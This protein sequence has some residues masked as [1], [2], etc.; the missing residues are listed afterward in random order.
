MPVVCVSLEKGPGLHESPRAWMFSGDSIDHLK[1]PLRVTVGGKYDTHG[2]KC[3]LTTDC[4]IDRTVGKAL[5][6]L[7]EEGANSEGQY[8]LQTLE[9]LKMQQCSSHLAEHQMTE[10]CQQL[11]DTVPGGLEVCVAPCPSLPYDIAIRPCGLPLLPWQK[12]QL[13]SSTSDVWHRLAYV[14]MRKLVRGRMRPYEEDDFHYLMVSSPQNSTSLYQEV[15]DRWRFFYFIPVAELVRENVV[16]ARGNTQSGVKSMYLDFTR[17]ANAPEHHPPKARSSRSSRFLKWRLDTSEAFPSQ[18]FAG[19]R[20]A[21][22]LFSGQQRTFLSVLEVSESKLAAPESVFSV[23]VNPNCLPSW[24]HMDGDSEAANSASEEKGVKFEEKSD[25][26]TISSHVEEKF[27][28]ARTRER[29]TAY[30]YYGIERDA[31]FLL[32]KSLRPTES[33]VGL[34]E[35]RT[36]LPPYAKADLAVRPVGCEEDL[37]LPVQV[38]STRQGTFRRGKLGGKPLSAIWSFGKVIGYTGMSVVCISLQRGLPEPT[39][40]WLFSGDYF[41]ELK[42][43]VL[44]IT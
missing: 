29:L 31:I 20:I 40:V 27:Q 33:F 38:K 26:S 34:E 16:S 2:S 39:K 36:H 13:K 22:L 3:S 15:T 17:D 11:F 6:S 25:R 44:H 41:D 35:P 21:Q 5:Y 4:S 32:R 1:G 19:T 12:V 30:D 24:K 14:K 28:V 18:N 10:K 7:W 37:W 42:S 23:G 8:K 43:N 9:T